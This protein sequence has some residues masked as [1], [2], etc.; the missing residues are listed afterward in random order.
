M[1]HFLEVD[2]L[3]TVELRA[4]LDHAQESKTDITVGTDCLPL[5]GKGVALVFEKASNR[6]RNSM[7]MAVI[8]LGGHPIYISGEEV[9]IGTRESAED[10]IRALAGY[11]ALVAAR[12]V[13]HSSLKRMAACNVVPVINLLSDQAHPMQALADLLTIVEHFGYPGSTGPDS[14]SPGLIGSTANTPLRV[15]FIGDA[16]NVWRSLAIGCAM[17]GIE[18][19][20]ATPARYAPN[21]ADLE[22]ASAAGTQV[23]GADAQV[24][25]AGT[26]VVVTEDPVEAVTGA[27]AVYTDVWTSMG[28]EKE[29]AQ[30]AT[31]F[32]SY[33]VDEEL[34][35][36]ARDD[37]VFMHCLPAHRGEEVSN[38]VLEGA[39]SVVWQQ[40]ENRMHAARGLLALLAT[41]WLPAQTQPITQ[42][43]TQSTET[44]PSS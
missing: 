21:P 12:V 30:R 11:H 42:P 20:I 25:G 27:H 44:G 15:A 28:Q 40:A 5:A 16:N 7:E 18:S 39:S 36:H 9:G 6:T 17:L 38:E 4:V 33:R 35:S 24:P 29:A 1:R 8:Q 37:C 10:V 19:V 41:K 2:D 13:D 26:Q 34:M 3:S 43:V 23:P 22:R 32:E 14:A 31:D